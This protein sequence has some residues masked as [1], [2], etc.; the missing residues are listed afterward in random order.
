MTLNL[1]KTIVSTF[2][3]LMNLLYINSKINR[4]YSG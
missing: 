2:S 1:W 4:W 3:P